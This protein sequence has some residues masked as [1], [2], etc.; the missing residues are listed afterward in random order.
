M[1]GITI[2]GSRHFYCNLYQSQTTGGA[3]P[4]HS[5]NVNTVSSPSTTMLSTFPDRFTAS[6]SA[7]KEHYPI[8]QKHLVDFSTL[9]ARCTQQGLLINRI[10]INLNIFA[11]VDHLINVILLSNCPK[12]QSISLITSTRYLIFLRKAETLAWK[13]SSKMMLP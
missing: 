1:A 4:S 10:Q 11:G 8:V 7:L 12:K 9:T 13:N 2:R 3:P 6:A 5:A